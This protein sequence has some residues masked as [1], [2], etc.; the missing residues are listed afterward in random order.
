MQFKRFLGT[1]SPGPDAIHA[2][3]LPFPYESTVTYGYGTK[4]GPAAVLEA[5]ASQVEFYDCDLHYSP[6]EKM[7]IFHAPLQ[8]IRGTPAESYESILSLTKK[9]T[10]AFPK[11]FFLG[12]GGEHATSYPFVQGLLESRILSKE[13]GILHLDAHADLRDTYGGSKLSH[14]SVM[15]RL[16]DDLHLPTVHVGVRAIGDDEP[17]YIEENDVPVFFAPFSMEQIPAILEKLPKNV[18]ITFDVDVLDPS[19][20]PSTGTPV[21]GGLQWYPT[22]DLLQSVFEKK[23]VIAMDIVE[24]APIKQLH[25]PVFLIAQLAYKCI[26]YKFHFNE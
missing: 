7:G 26:G 25:A 11:A 10:A 22:L 6:C 4:G 14:A 12:L 9:Y 3:V 20:M 13:V 19:I 5:A 8:E 24:L 18:F 17:K 23:N 16:R 21:P 1:D 2:L 15:R